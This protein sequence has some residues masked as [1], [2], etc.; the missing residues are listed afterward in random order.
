[1]AV[2]VALGAAYAATAITALAALRRTEPRAVLPVTATGAL[3][4]ALTALVAAILH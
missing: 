1:M 3:I 2:T 4:L